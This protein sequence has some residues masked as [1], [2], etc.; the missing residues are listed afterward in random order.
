VEIKR[1]IEID[2]LTLIAISIIAWSIANFLHEVI[3]HAGS[4]A[5][6]GIPVRAV[7]TT[8]MYIDWSQIDSATENQIIHAAGAGLNLLT[9]IIALLCLRS[10]KVT[11][12]ATR[13]FLWLF[14][15]VS[16]IIVTINLISAPLIGGGDWS[17]IIQETEN[18]EMWKAII[19][20][21]GVILTIPG[22]A[23]PLR[24]WL[25]DMRG[26]RNTL[27]KITI[28]PVLTM[29]IVQS[30]SLVG[31]P[32]SRL[33]PEYNHLLASVFAYMHFVL[34]AILVNILPIPRATRP[35]ESI[36]LTR[37]IIYLSIGLI[38]GIFFIAVLGPGWGP[39]DQ[40]PRLGYWN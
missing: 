17:V 39:L 19:I 35:I 20:G 15:T 4:A 40:D 30:L 18:Q 7:S 31:S 36:R 11:D 25:P 8:T 22:Y 28:I 9:G 14:S 5:L 27:L 37:S 23:L 32:F 2:I 16:F 24:Y 33:P 12:S 26:H 10:Q 13:Y 3:G 34:W 6:L 29:I 38:V 21:V 1:R